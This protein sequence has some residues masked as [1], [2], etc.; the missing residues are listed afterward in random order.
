[1]QEYLLTS[2]LIISAE[3]GFHQLFFPVNIYSAH[4]IAQNTYPP[5]RVNLLIF[6]PS[7]EICAIVEPTLSL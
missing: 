5:P 4:T 1:M 6:F 3:K 2:P 7:S